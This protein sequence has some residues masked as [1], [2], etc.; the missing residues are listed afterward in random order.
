[1]AASVARSLVGKTALVTGSSSGIGL[2]IASVLASKGA[3]VVVHGVGALDEIDR[4]ARTIAQQHEVKCVASN[5][6]L[7]K[8]EEPVKAMVDL[9]HS[10]LGGPVDILVNNAGIQ[11]VCPVEDF[12]LEAWE[13][14]MAVNLTAAF[15]ASRA[16]LPAMR[17]NKWGRIV[18]IASVHGVV[19]SANKSAYVA[20]KHGLIGFT[21]A[22]ALET[23][24]SGVTAN[25]I[26]PGW[27]LT[28][29]VEAQI[30]AR[31]ATS[32]RSFEEEK[33]DMLREKQP[34][35]QFATPEDLGELTAFL[36]SQAAANMTGESIAMDGG[37]TAQ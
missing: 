34:Q 28:P 37:W 11:H 19:A 23:A 26:K 6:D 15:L 25:A 32:G 13:R 17:E 9:S 30:Q 29:L 10:A 33:D 5:A 4:V 31:A 8:G 1:M 14:I 3:N 24:N 7:L 21:K 27:V 35:R 16:V 18:N 36:C 20:A 12:T 2:G 22:L